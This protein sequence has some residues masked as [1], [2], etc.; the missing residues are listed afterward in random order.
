MNVTLPENKVFSKR[1]L[2]IYAVIIFICVISIIVAF[3]VQFYARIDLGKFIGLGEETNIVKKSE[4]EIQNIKSNFDKVFTNAIEENEDNQSKKKDKEK[5]LVY[6]N[7]EKKET[8][9]NSYDLEVHIPYVNLDNKA[10]NNF[11]EEINQFVKKT[12]EVLESENKNVIYTVEYVANDY[13]GILSLMIRSNLKEGTSA[14]RVIIETFNYDLR[15]NKEV[16]LEE[17][18]RIKQIEKSDA[19]KTIKDEIKLEQD[20][21]E[22]L[23]SLGYNIYSRD[24]NND[25]YKVENSDIFYITKDILYVIYPYGNEELTCEMDLIIF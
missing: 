12:Q 9:L 10:A 20:R 1:Q 14:Q 8:K 23:K 13:D 18:L 17:A 16:T 5:S 7:Y 2:I 22:S 25:R 4:E 19:E 24:A 15:N 21:A 3:Y 11:N 6:T